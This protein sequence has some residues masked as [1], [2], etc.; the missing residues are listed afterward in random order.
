MEPALQPGLAKSR[1]FVR[2]AGGR[3]P[4]RE[5]QEPTCV[6][7]DPAALYPGPSCPFSLAAGTARGCVEVALHLGGRGQQA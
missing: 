3:S 5:S 6:E 4:Q 7:V 2:W 1:G